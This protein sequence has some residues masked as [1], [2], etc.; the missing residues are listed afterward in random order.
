MID[1][2]AIL[3]EANVPWTKQSKHSTDGWTQVHCPFCIPRDHSFH[4]GINEDNGAVGCWVCGSHRLYETLVA[5]GIERP[6][7][8]LKEHSDSFQR[9]RAPKTRLP[10]L[11]LPGVF[12]PLDG[13]Y[14]QYLRGRGFDPEEIAQ[15][16]GA[17]SGGPF[18][19]MAYRIVIPFTVRGQIVTWQGRDATGRQ[20]LRYD[21]LKDS[22]S[23]LT[24]KETVYGLDQATGDS[25]VI[26]EGPLDVW[27]AG[28]GA[29]CLCGTA[30]TDT[31]VGLIRSKFKKVTVVFDNEP[32]AQAQGRELAVT[33]GSLGLQARNA[34]LKDV[35]DF[36]DLPT[37]EAHALLK[38]LL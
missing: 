30:Y 9:E 15:T 3:D 13:I 27:K 10:S 12:G 26:I 4:M 14:A 6:S 23:V 29:G 2:A 20:K 25:I 11:T 37:N 22:E 18:G 31:Q 7:A 38:E 34:C 28:P 35:K 1:I 24:T 21:G 19:K 36:G 33:L 17:M 8:S 5:L 32:K 16:W